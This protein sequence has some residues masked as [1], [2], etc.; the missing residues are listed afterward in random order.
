M[1]RNSVEYGQ[2]RLKLSRQYE[3]RYGRTLSDLDKRNLGIRGFQKGG[4]V[5]ASEGRGID[6]RELDRR[7]NKDLDRL[8]K[9]GDT[10]KKSIRRTEE[11]KIRRAMFGE[12]TYASGGLPIDE[13]FEGIIRRNMRIAT[14]RTLI[15]PELFQVIEDP[16]FIN[17]FDDADSEEYR[18]LLAEIKRDIADNVNELYQ[19][20][21][22]PF[23][24]PREAIAGMSEDT[25]YT[26]MAS[27]VRSARIA[28]AKIKQITEVAKALG[29]SVQQV[30]KVSHATLFAN[31]ESAF[32]DTGGHYFRD[33]NL[34]VDY[35]PNA[36]ENCQ[37]V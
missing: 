21:K 5:Y 33:A 19:L 24:N 26:E 20:H 2:C 7:T 28:D 32:G 31:S 29:L 3:A 11:S 16:R 23:L 6:G 30:E 37:N 18:N 27:V 22:A 1:G 4:I 34:M 36:I 13:S 25:P 12:Q 9:S 14:G 10:S 35:I 17:S 8:P 15:V